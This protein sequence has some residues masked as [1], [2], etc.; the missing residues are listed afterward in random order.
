MASITLGM[1]L[2]DFIIFLHIGRQYSTRVEITVRHCNI[3]A[4]VLR[5]IL[6]NTSQK[7][8]VL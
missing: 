3:I 8:E 1:S 2:D 4:R 5:V 7:I 6:I